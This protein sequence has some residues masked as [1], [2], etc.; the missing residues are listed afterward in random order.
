MFTGTGCHGA[1]ATPTEVIGDV[2]AERV[3][4]IDSTADSTLAITGVHYILVYSRTSDK[5]HSE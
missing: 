4:D 2:R 1:V 3:R 5:G